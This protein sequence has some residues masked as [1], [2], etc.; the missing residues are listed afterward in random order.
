MH[1]KSVAQINGPSI[2]TFNIHCDSDK[3][4][5]EWIDAI[6]QSVPTPSPPWPTGR[7]AT[8]PQLHCVRCTPCGIA[9]LALRRSLLVTKAAA[10]AAAVRRRLHSLLFFDL[11]FI[12]QN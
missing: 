7:S 10:A 12:F 6:S 9:R 1:A 4:R 11:F 5:E 8:Y 2:R 3:E